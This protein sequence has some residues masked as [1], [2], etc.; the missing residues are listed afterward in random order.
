MACDGDTLASLL[1]DV[2]DS[3]SDTDSWLKMAALTVMFLQLLKLI[4]LSLVL[5]SCQPH[6][7]TSV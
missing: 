1:Y 7:V 4:L 5:T 6:R 2:T 3:D